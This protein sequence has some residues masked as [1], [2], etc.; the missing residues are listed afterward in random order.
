MH[1]PAACGALP[2]QHSSVHLEPA[3]TGASGAMLE[4]NATT[5]ITTSASFAV[6]TVLNRLELRRSICRV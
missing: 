6:L 4:K 3:D 2:A 5:S 1:E